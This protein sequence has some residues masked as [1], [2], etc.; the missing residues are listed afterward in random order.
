MIARAGS[1]WRLFVDL[2][3]RL[4]GVVLVKYYTRTIEPAL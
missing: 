4:D 2:V 3:R 1:C